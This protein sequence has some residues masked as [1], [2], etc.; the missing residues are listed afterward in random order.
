MKTLLSACLSQ[1]LVDTLARM[2]SNYLLIRASSLTVEKPMNQRPT[3]KTILVIGVPGFVG[4][5]IAR[6][7][8][9][10]GYAVRCLALTPAK[11]SQLVETGAQLVPG[12]I[13]D[14]VSGL[15]LNILLVG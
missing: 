6:Q 15:Q 8:P 14:P 12:D 4:S 2:S 10:D 3:V 5:H 11:L 13:T 1:Q 9:A 7:L